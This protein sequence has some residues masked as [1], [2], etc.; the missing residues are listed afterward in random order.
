MLEVYAFEVH[1]RVRNLRRS[2]LEADLDNQ[3][4]GENESL[5]EKY[6]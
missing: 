1:H 6:I 4:G 3:E 5:Y 2:D